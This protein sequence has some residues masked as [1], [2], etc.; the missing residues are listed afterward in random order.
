MCCSLK[1]S[2]NEESPTHG[3][4]PQIAKPTPIREALGQQGIV[5]PRYVEGQYRI[6]CPQCEGGQNHE[7]SL[8]VAIKEGGKSAMWICHRGSCQWNGSEFFE[9]KSGGKAGG[10]GH[11][12]S[13]SKVQYATEKGRRIAPT[14]PKPS[15]EPPGE[16][17]LDFFAKRCISRETVERNGVQQESFYSSAHKR[18]MV[19]VAFPYRRE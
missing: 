2:T 12:N 16:K 17:V 10:K 9:A 6:R 4:S 14:K 8:A 15:F 7:Q 5:L 1:K 13:N 18:D 3:S 11:G 19:A